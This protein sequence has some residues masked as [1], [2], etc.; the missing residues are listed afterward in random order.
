MLLPSQLNK[1]QACEIEDK[2][3]NKDHTRR[4]KT[5]EHDT[6]RQDT[7]QRLQ[8]WQLAKDNAINCDCKL[9]QV[10]LWRGACLRWM[11]VR[12]AMW[13]SDRGAFVVGCYLRRFLWN[14]LN[15][16]SLNAMQIDVVGV[17]DTP[18]SSRRAIEVVV[19]VAAFFSKLLYSCFI[20]Q[21]L[22]VVVHSGCCRQRAY[23]WTP[24]IHR[25]LPLRWMQYIIMLIIC[26]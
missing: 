10:V 2:F 18:S 26:D 9:V 19:V 21:Q 12:L 14:Q 7:Q 3:T 25:L 20:V 1:K 6:A 5:W 17:E 4:H 8:Q 22:V 24:K 23:T 15:A 11:R 13:R 16:K